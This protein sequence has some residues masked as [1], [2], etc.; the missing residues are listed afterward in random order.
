MAF[1]ILVSSAKL[2]SIELTIDSFM[3]LIKIMKRIAMFFKR[4]RK[5]LSGLYKFG[6]D[7][8]G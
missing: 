3:S 7:S 4:I 1:R 8:K 5:Q 6:G 2:R